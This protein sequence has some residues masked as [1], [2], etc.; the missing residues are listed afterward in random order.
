MVKNKIH[1][2]LFIALL[3]LTFW[4]CSQ[5]ESTEGVEKEIDRMLSTMTIDEKIGQLCQVH[6]PGGVTNNDFIQNIKNG[7]VGSVLNEA[8]P[9]VIREMQ[10]IAV[11]ESRLGIPLLFGRDVIHGFKTIFPINIGLAATFNPQL[12]QKGAEIAA[13]EATSVGINWNFA[14]MV[15][16]SRDP[17]WGRMAESF[18]EDPFLTTKMAIAMLNGFQGDD[19]R[20]PNTMAAC[21][22]HFA[23]YGAAQG[24]RDYHTT[25]ISDVELWNTYFPPFKALADAGIA[26]FMTGFNE[27]NGV[28]ASGNQFLFRDVLKNGWNFKGFV[29]SDWASIVEM[30]EHGFVSDN[31]EAA[32]SAILAGVD[33]EMASTSYKDHLQGLI[34]SG[35]ISET[36]IDDAVR[37]ILRVKHQLGLFQNPYVDLEKVIS[38]PPAHHLEMAKKS[39]I[40]SFVLLK[41]EK[42]TL[43][44]KTTIRNV[45]IIGPMANDRYEQLGT[46]IFDGDTNLSITPRMAIEQLVGK[47]RTRYAKGLKTTRSKST[48]LFAEAIKAAQQS[49]VALLFVG[50][51]SILTGEAHSRAYLDLPGAQNE[52][53]KAVAKTGKPVVLVIMTPRPL[54]IGEISE[55]ADA[56]L[57]A[58]HPGTMA[59]PALADVLFGLESPSGKLPVTFPKAAGQIPIFYAQKNSGRPANMDTFVPIDE[60]PVRS[61]QTSLGNTNHYLDI[62]FAPLYPFGFGL[63]YTTF[64]YSGLTLSAQNIDFKDSLT[65]SVTLS[66]T[67]N[68]E[69]EEVVQLYV[70]DLVASITRPVKELKDFQRVRLSPG[71]RTIVSFNVHPS[72]LG[73]YNSKGEYIIEK[74]DFQVWVGGSSEAELTEV[75][76]LAESLT[77]SGAEGYLKD[78]STSLNCREHFQ[79]RIL[80]GFNINSPTCNVGCAEIVDFKNPE[81][82]Q[83]PLATQVDVEP[84]C[85]SVFSLSPVSHRLRLWLLTFNHVV[86]VHKNNLT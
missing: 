74:G 11:E 73:F 39:A 32:H 37:R 16:I 15:D 7:G 86:V 83:L 76:R 42:K 79:E 26:T 71:E 13:L 82:V 4:G 57:Y 84:R 5:P 20:K 33:M 62:G 45:A 53:I 55:Y 6:S 47:E 65:V 72:N 59:G 80:K 70:R 29:V 60:I 48:E 8:R 49:D 35:K 85:G 81:G 58:W 1:K 36:L 23:G 40:Q 64:A 41:N 68:F 77:L 3:V 69:A 63:S 34:Q 44:L 19:L 46:W 43:P 21:A 56:V 25:D 17:R 2:I 24:G 27:L 12:V 52:L 75:F 18:G 28:P 78:I 31:L 51:E 10:R 30:R 54:T 9:V 67:G 61:F 22:K 14:P 38:T 50:E 66:N